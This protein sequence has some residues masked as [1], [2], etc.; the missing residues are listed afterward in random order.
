MLVLC[1]PLL[2]TILLY[3]MQHESLA[4]L[5]VLKITS[6]T[7]LASNQTTK[8]QHI[9]KAVSAVMQS[10]AN[11]KQGQ[12]TKI[13]LDRA[14]TVAKPLGQLQSTQLMRQPALRAHLFVIKHTHHC[15]VQR[16]HMHFGCRQ[17]HKSTAAIAE[18]PFVHLHM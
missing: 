13:A 5:R 2:V 18:Q 7:R 3:L 16:I 8:Q 1:A 14:L 11:S 15:G 12:P 10:R 6:R 17:L 4:G 9:I